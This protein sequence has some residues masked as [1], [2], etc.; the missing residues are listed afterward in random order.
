MPV[1]KPFT[2]EY[3]SMI[4]PYEHAKEVMSLAKRKKRVPKNGAVWHLSAEEATLAKMPKFNGHACGTGI[5]G[6][7]KYNRS[8]SKRAW[9][10]ELA[11]E[12]RNRGSHS[13]GKDIPL[14]WRRVRA[15]DRKD[16]CG[17]H[18]RAKRL[19]LTG[20]S[21]PECEMTIFARRATVN[22]EVVCYNPADHR[23]TFAASSRPR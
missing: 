19:S 20:M 8:R 22:A 16:L 21:S 12:T 13:F 18:I 1:D 7:T 15:A 9:K 2:A 6:D 5:H 23:H 11:R 14:V 4:N 3:L 17:A 10:Q